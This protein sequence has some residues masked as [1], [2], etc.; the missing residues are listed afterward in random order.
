MPRVFFL[1]VA[2]VA[3][4][5]FL[6]LVEAQAQGRHHGRGHQVAD[7]RVSSFIDLREAYDRDG[8]GAVTQAEVDAA[9]AERF[10]AFDPDQSGDLSLE[11]YEALWL[12]AMRERMVRRFQRHDADG[13]GVVTTEEFQ[14][15]TATMVERRDRTGDGALTIEDARARHGRGGGRG[16]RAE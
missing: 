10:A 11:E 9:R 8:D 6:V 3:L 7:K 16:P 2:F 14:R 4:S 12:D 1:S 15:R 13:D 5:T